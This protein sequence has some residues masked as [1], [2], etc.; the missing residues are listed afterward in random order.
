V[1]KEN[2]EGGA[3]SSLDTT[4]KEDSGREAQEH[5]CEEDQEHTDGAD[6][7]WSVVSV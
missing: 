4:L 1:S 3:E 2:K 5:G 6:D 7:E